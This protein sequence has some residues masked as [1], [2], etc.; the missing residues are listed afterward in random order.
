MKDQYEDPGGL[1]SRAYII[2]N[3]SGTW[4][5]TKIY[6]EEGNRRNGAASRVL[7]AVCADADKQD[8]ELRMV[9]QSD[10]SKDCLTNPQL[11]AWYGRHGFTKIRHSYVLHRIPNGRGKKE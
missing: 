8:A 1:D 7:K 3:I 10:G 2:H 5:I 4:T 9:V 6:T 11:M